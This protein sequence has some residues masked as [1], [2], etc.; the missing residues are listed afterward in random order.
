VSITLLATNGDSFFRITPNG[1]GWK[2]TAKLTATSAES[3]AVSPS[4]PGTVFVGC[5]GEGLFRSLDDGE[6]FERLDFPQAHVLSLAISPADGAVYAGC[7]PSMLFRSRDNGDTWEELEALRKLPSS[8]TWSFPPRPWT[9][10]V[11]WIAPNP[12]DPK[13]MLVGIEL[14]GVM[15][16]DDDGV[17]WEDHRPGAVK[18]CHALAWHP[19][20]PGRAY[21]AGGNGSAWSHD[22]GR[23]WQRVDDGRDHEYR[24]YLM[25]LAVD[26]ADPD[27][28]FVTASPT[29]KHAHGAHMPN[30]KP[31]V[32]ADAAIYRWDG[33]GPWRR[34]EG[35][36]PASLESFPYA[37]TIAD[38]AVFAGFEDGNIWV[39]LEVGERWEQLQLSGDPIRRVRGLGYSRG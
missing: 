17:T 23:S 9:H 16:S 30:A 11:R 3:L 27:R 19:T 31:P 1:S 36:L 34:L 15:R 13:L 24:H 12:V 4:H 33:G 22:G 6:T 25:G 7:E 2:S 39:G 35:G 21:E 10:H 28:W 14:G 8:S 26:P 38:D 32:H 37:L 5:R 18:D 20:V 29:P